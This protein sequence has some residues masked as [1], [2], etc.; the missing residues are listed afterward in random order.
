MYC[1]VAFYKAFV[2]YAVCRA[3][4]NKN[5]S[6]ESL[7]FTFSAT[8][9]NWAQDFKHNLHSVFRSVY[10][11]KLLSL[12]CVHLKL[13]SCAT[14]RIGADYVTVTEHAGIDPEAKARASGSEREMGQARARENFSRSE[15]EK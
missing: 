3:A 10:R 15:R 13:V 4:I 14:V 1:T 7:N 9:L 8:A 12:Y 5:L 2:D 11:V 6:A